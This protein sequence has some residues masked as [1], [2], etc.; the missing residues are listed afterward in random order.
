MKDL[1]A[2]EWLAAFPLLALTVLVGVAPFLV[3][4]V[5]HATTEALLP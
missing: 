5:V 2:R 1:G 3:L 4:D